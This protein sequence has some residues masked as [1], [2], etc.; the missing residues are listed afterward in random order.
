MKNRLK[1]LAASLLLT[2]LIVFPALS[3]TV[4]RPTKASVTFVIRNAGLGVDGSFG[5]FAGTLAFDPAN[6]ATGKLTA[7]VETNTLSTGIGLRDNHLKKEDYF[8]VAKHPRITLTSV[9][10]EKKTGNAYTGIFDLT[11]KGT[12]RRVTVPFTFTQTGKAGHF[13][14]QFTINRLDYKVGKSNMFLSDNLTVS[15]DVQ[16]QATD[17]N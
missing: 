9:S 8:D 2:G 11:L 15:L 6:P 10:V 7:T 13:V 3:Q 12:T 17:P 14:G 4:W 16:A 1:Q 5:G